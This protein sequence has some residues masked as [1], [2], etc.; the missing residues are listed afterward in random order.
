[1]NFVCRCYGQAQGDEEVP[2]K[3]SIA[4]I[5]Y[6]I[7]LRAILLVS[8][9]LFLSYPFKSTQRYANKTSSK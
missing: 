7:V 5:S 6:C 9:R 1:M 2:V 8:K 4:M 3:A